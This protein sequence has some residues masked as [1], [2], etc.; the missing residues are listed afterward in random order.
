MR[1]RIE[2]T[3]SSSAPA[4]AHVMAKLAHGLADDALSTIILASKS[5]V[6]IAP[7]MEHH[8][9]ENAATQA[10]MATLARRGV[11]FVGPN[12]GR[13]A[14]GAVGSGRLVDTAEILEE[15]N[16]DSVRESGSGG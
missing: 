6:L 9:Y 3:Q 15:L 7:A 2:Q 1:S 4:T 14:S 11:S 10:N 8:M 12:A 5:P 13:L 16:G